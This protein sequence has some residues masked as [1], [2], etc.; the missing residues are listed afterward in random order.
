MRKIAFVHDFIFTMGGAERVLLAL[1][2][3]FP[4]APIYTAFADPTLVA[5]HF[6]QADIRTSSLQGKFIT[7]YP[8]LLVGAMPQAIEEF[9]FSGFDIVLSSSGAF[10]H[11][12]ITHPGTEHICYCHTPMRYAWDWTHQ[13]LVEKGWNTGLRGW[14]ARNQL[15][16]LRQWDW[17]ASRRVDVWLANSHTVA[18]RI[19]RYYQ[20]DSQV[21]YPPVSVPLLPQ[22]RTYAD[23]LGKQYDKYAVVVSRLSPYKRLELLIDVCNGKMPLVIIGSGN[24][25]SALRVYAAKQKA[26]IIFAGALSDVDRSIV[27]RDA[28]WFL[29]AAEEDFGI[30]TAE[31][32]LLGTPVLGL[33]IGGTA[34]QVMPG[35]NGAL[36]SAP[37]LEA[38]RQAMAMQEP[39]WTRAEIAADAV[40]R[41]GTEQFARAIEQLCQ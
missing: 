28:Q 26:T 37:T 16:R 14:L 30:A 7:H 13:Y 27:V 3:Q 11:G 5:T 1:H 31:S 2:H 41:F 12:V 6:P 17:Y 29:Y 24:H 15:S 18:R 34:E 21:V 19:E 8:G 22:G 33:G 35:K 25:E 39:S 32:L 23:V 38:Y 20:Q 9:D 40:S 10:S 4:E 36:A